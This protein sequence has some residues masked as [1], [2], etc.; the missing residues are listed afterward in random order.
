M[1]TAFC[2]CPKCDQQIEFA[3]ENSGMMAKCP[4]CDADL[5]LPAPEPENEVL[6]LASPT[7]PQVIVEEAKIDDSILEIRLNSGLEL[8][9]KAMRLYDEYSLSHCNAQKTKAMKLLR[10]VSTGIGAIGD[11][12]WVLAASAVVGAL[13]GALSA[14]ASSEGVSLLTEALEMEKRIRDKGAFK[15]IK[16]ILQIENPIPGL[17]RVPFNRDVQVQVT[18]FLGPKMENRTVPSAY[19]HNGD[20]FIVVRN[21]DDSVCAIRWSSVE[22]YQ[23]RTGKG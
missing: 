14:G 7:A 22:R 10:G 16:S 9:V 3:V 15:P 5:T 13:E 19:I 23:K 6:T 18:G 1:S 8:K 17:W 2:S 21:E 20:E 12:G 4:N 11:V